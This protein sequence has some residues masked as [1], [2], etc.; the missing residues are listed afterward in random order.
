ML[1]PLIGVLIGTVTGII[2]GMHSN[3]VAAFLVSLHADGGII[4]AMAVTHLFI[5]IIPSLYL[6]LPDETTAV[7][8]LPG[9]QLVK[10][11]RGY[12][13]IMAHAAGVL[14]TIIIVTPFLFFV[15]PF[16]PY[17]QSFLA[18]IIPLLLALALVTFLSNDKI[19]WRF[20]LLILAGV[21]GLLSMN[22]FTDPLLPLLSGLF[23]VP[24]LLITSTSKIPNQSISPGTVT[25][26]MR[27]VLPIGWFAGSIV[28]FLPG[29]GT[30]QAAGIA[31]IGKKTNPKTMLML[32][33][34]IMAANFLFS[35]AT[36]VALGKARNGVV[37]QVM[38]YAPMSFH[39]YL[40][41]VLAAGGIAYLVT[42]LCAR[43]F[44]RQA[45]MLM[46]PVIRYALLVFI[47]VMVMALSGWNGILV[48]LTATAIGMLPLLLN[49]ERS[50]LMAALVVPVLVMLWP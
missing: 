17:I 46:Q 31:Q 10:A 21:L 37:A 30:A 24:A 18:P 16:L 50:I 29:V 4:I 43:L 22:S 33:S 3:L 15:V 26:T 49:I 28:G 1:S 32:L 20:L 42:C 36:S 12:E 2:P 40:A 47:F 45:H 13:G 9:Q 38:E 6:S 23:G 8:L 7:S 11:G 44:A 41:T 39:Q 27:A 25:K 35:L 5:T 34:S 19:A 48:L 14:L